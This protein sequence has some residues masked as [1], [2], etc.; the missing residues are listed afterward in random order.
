MPER[1]ADVE[2][3]PGRHRPQA[4]ASPD[5]GRRAGVAADRRG[6]VFE[7]I[8]SM[9]GFLPEVLKDLTVPLILA[10]QEEATHLN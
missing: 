6:R 2:A 7:S 3:P 10:I 4:S 9:A 1:S 8:R 5:R